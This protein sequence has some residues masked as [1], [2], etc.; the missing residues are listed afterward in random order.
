[1]NEWPVLSKKV[2]EKKGKET[3]HIINNNTIALDALEKHHPNC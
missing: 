2:V 1:V 3:N